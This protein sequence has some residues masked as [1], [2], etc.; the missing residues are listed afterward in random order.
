MFP[1]GGRLRAAQSRTLGQTP[2]VVKQFTGQKAIVA[3]VET[4]VTS[5]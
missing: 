5:K 1:D 4:L 3:Q 2:D